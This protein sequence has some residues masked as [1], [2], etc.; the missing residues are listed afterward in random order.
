VYALLEAGI[1]VFAFLMPLISAGLNDLYVAVARSFEIGNYQVSLV[2]FTLSF[3]VLVVPATLM[4]GTLPVIIKFFVDRQA[5]LG[6][7]VG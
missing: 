5:D 2:R 4:G 1:G 3:L 6:W 7:R